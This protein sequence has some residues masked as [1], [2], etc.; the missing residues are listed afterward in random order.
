MFTVGNDGAGAAMSLPS[1]FSGALVPG[2]SVSP[3]ADEPSDPSEFPVSGRPPCASP[4]GSEGGCGA[5]EGEAGGDGA[6]LSDASFDAFA[7]RMAATFFASFFTFARLWERTQRERTCAPTAGTPARGRMAVLT[8][9]GTIPA[10]A[11]HRRSE[12]NAYRTDHG[13]SRRTWTSLGVMPSCAL[14]VL[15]AVALGFVSCLNM[16]SS[17]FSCSRDVRLRCL[18]SFGTYG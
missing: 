7:S 4:A 5:G 14:S 2:V 8:D 11:E 13:R 3:D 15:R 16:F 18:T 1:S 17:T 12:L 10:C 9:F 6:D